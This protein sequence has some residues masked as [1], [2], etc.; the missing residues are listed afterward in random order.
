LKKFICGDPEHRILESPMG[1]S[2]LISEVQG[3][4]GL[5]LPS[6]Q[7]DPKNN[8]YLFISPDTYIPNSL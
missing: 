1:F 5:V 3:L 7:T 2:R 6:L 4:L 8:F